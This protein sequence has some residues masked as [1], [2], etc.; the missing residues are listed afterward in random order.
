MKNYLLLLLIA[1]LAV[2]CSK[3]NGEEEETDIYLYLSD[4]D[5]LFESTG[6]EDYF[7]ISC[8]SSWT[9]TNDVSWLQLE[10][11]RGEGNA[12][13]KLTAIAGELS[14][15]RNTVITVKSGATEESFTVIQEKTDRIITFNDI[16]FL[17]AIIKHHPEADNNGD[18]KISEKEASKVLTLNLSGMNVAEP[19]IRNMDELKHFTSLEYL[20][21]YSHE[22][23]S[24]DVSN[25]IKLT[26][27][28]CGANPIT[29]LDVSKNT[30]LT[31]LS[32]NDGA[33]LTSL[34]LS[35]NT[36][37]KYLNCNQNK[38]TS[39]D[40]SKNVALEYLE[41]WGCQL[42]SLDVSHNTA[43]TNLWC[44]DNQLASL[45]IS[46]NTALTHLLCSSNPFTSLDL[47]KNTVLE[48][49]NCI[50]DKIIELDLSNN[51]VLKKLV[52][53]LYYNSSGGQVNNPNNTIK[54]LY[55]YKYHNLATSDISH[56]QKYC[57]NL[58]I[59][60]AE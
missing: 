10:K 24:L 37:L 18:G 43:L 6:G 49:L 52:L 35:K 3:D 28:Y 33:Q 39:L 17:N 14:D 45:D 59:T 30:A 29:S 36:A 42:S 4:T 41:C 56:I 9:V 44:G 51:K 31:T 57:P 47:S 2:S 21:C 27:L 32:C 40:L 50:S 58:T 20:N 12:R 22:I 8:N 26:T 60:Y 38:L 46:K 55:L 7:N 34:D 19:E 5:I 23:T 11:N 54:T 13:V 15:D 53:H 1:V 25:N 16:R 48:D